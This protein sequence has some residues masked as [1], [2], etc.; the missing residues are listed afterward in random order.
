MFAIIEN[1]V[2]PSE[3]TMDN[4]IKLGTENCSDALRQELELEMD[5]LEIDSE[6]RCILA[7]LFIKATNDVVD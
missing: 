4:S 6:K 2:K 5:L 1:N 3:E 7:L